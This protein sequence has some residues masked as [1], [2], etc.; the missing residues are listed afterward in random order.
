MGSN[1][2]WRAASTTAL[3]SSSNLPALSTPGNLY[4]RGHQQLNEFSHRN[5]GRHPCLRAL[6]RYPGAGSA[7]GR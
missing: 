6:L 7:S 5:G 3:P 1:P 4:Q 2:I